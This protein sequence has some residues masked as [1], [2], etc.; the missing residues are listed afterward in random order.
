MPYWAFSL[1]IIT[2][3]TVFVT[4]SWDP[5]S[6]ILVTDLQSLYVGFTEAA[7]EERELYEKLLERHLLEAR[8][9]LLLRPQE[10]SLIAPLDTAGIFNPME[11]ERCVAQLSRKNY[12]VLTIKDLR[13]RPLFAQPPTRSLDLTQ[14]R[15][16]P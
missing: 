9:L 4:M 3:A 8:P 6:E 2:V 11:A 15:I 14:T 5:A 16:V 10:A 13:V 1:F 7:C 12:G